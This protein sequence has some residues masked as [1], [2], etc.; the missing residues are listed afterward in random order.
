MFFLSDGLCIYANYVTTQFCGTV[1]MIP[2]LAT[3]KIH[4]VDR[5]N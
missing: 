1:R 5:M 4:E 3:V 2:V